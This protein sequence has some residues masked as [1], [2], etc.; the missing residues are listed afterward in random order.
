[1]ARQTIR[2]PTT[3]PAPA[4]EPLITRRRGSLAIM[5]GADGHAGSLVHDAILTSAREQ[6][7][8]DVDW[9]AFSATT[10]A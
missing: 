9:Q 2:C 3:T 7:W 8:V 5:V 10:A 6:R 1:M 4:R